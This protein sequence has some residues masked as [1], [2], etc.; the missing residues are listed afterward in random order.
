MYKFLQHLSAIV[1]DMMLR[2]IEI[3]RTVDLIATRGYASQQK[4]NG[5]S[6]GSKTPLFS[7]HEYNETA[8]AALLCEKLKQRLNIA[9]ISDAG[10]H[11][12]DQQSWLSAILGE[13]VRQ[14]FVSIPYGLVVAPMQPLPLPRWC[15]QD[16]QWIDLFSKDLF[17]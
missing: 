5:L 7:L 6:W 15:L 8:R 10:K 2:A 1:T 11:I 12:A 17:L 14:I 4:I 13:S 9:L 16:C 3:L